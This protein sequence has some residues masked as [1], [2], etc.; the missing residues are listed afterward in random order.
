MAFSVYR[1][2][3]IA[4]SVSVR[5]FAVALGLS[6]M[7]HGMLASRIT[8]QPEPAVPGTFRPLVANLAPAIESPPEIPAVSHPERPDPPPPLI[9]RSRSEHRTAAPQRR[10]ATHVAGERA[11]H[12][13]PPERGQFVAP[14]RYY[15]AEELDVYPR[16]RQPIQLARRD[17]PALRIRLRMEVSLSEAG[18]VEELTLMDSDVP[19]ALRDAVEAML[20][21]ALFFPALKDGRPVKS[22][23]VIGVDG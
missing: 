9:Q 3:G 4:R 6:M 22:R 20:R 7:V 2:A 12:D 16:L 14:E 18:V 19:R 17:I 21:A 13:L 1:F 5:P 8:A 11:L 23:V 10:R 15:T